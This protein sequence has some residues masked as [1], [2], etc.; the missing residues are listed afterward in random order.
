MIIFIKA[1]FKTTDDQTNINNYRAAAEITECHIISKLLIIS[2][3]NVCQKSTCFQWTTNFF[4]NIIE[5]LC[6][7]YS[8]KLY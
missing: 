1:N 6:F 3:K 2:C 8:T 7:L 5:L 4:V